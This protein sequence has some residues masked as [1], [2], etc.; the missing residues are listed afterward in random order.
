MTIDMFDPDHKPLLPATTQRER[1]FRKNNYRRGTKERQCGN[2]KYFVVKHFSKKY[3]KCRCF[4][5]SAS[6]STDINK[7]G[8][9]DLHDPK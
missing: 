7:T 3:F 9:C 6:M 4:S 1:F 2:C 8:V 5:L